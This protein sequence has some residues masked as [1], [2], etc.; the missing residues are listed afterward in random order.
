M[1]IDKNQDKHAKLATLSLAASSKSHHTYLRP[2]SYTLVFCNSRMSLFH[3]SA[4]LSH[5][6]IKHK[7]N[8]NVRTWQYLKIGSSFGLSR[9][10]PRYSTDSLGLFPSLCLSGL[11]IRLYIHEVDRAGSCLERIINSM[12]HKNCQQC[13]CGKGFG[14][15]PNRRNYLLL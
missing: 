6:T 8:L 13:I 9:F 10:I 2:K 3:L 7:K 11:W 4:V 12:S 14:G 5:L 15:W 1:L